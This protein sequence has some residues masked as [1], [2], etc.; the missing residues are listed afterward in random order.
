M[1]ATLLALLALLPLLLP[2]CTR[3]EPSTSS[4]PTRAASDATA[5]APRVSGTAPSSATS[6]TKTEPNGGGLRFVHDDFPRALAQA[7]AENKALFVDAWA[8]WCHTCLSMQHYVLNQPA[9]LP[10]G[11]RVV[12]S[13]IDTE[14]ENNAGFLDR[15][16]VSVW[17]TFF[18]IDPESDRVLGYWPGSGSVYEMRGFIENSL[19][20]MDALRAGK[21]APD[22]PLG[23]LLSAKAAQ[24]KGQYARA[25]DLYQ[26]V[27]TQAPADFRRRS[28]ALFGW[29]E[30]L[31]RLSRA[32]PCVDVGLKH[33]REIAGAARPTDYT[34][35]VFECTKGLP[36]AQREKPRRI[37]IERLRELGERPSPEMSPD[38]H[39]DA[40]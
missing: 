39:A 6:H 23:L 9:L 36:A 3:G 22:S 18:I 13:A 1:R 26:R 15:H 8:Q 33:L 34:H 37:L 27:V 25:A 7:K 30:S 5:P 16:E 17:P 38:D 19:E 21:L 32:A 24:A 28:E 29:I 35:L 20:S 11:E 31:F 40:L 12:F 2:S 4:K 14:R 10:L